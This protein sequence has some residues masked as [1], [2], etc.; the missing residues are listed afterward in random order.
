MSRIAGILYGGL[1]SYPYRTTGLK[2]GFGSLETYNGLSRPSF[3]LPTFLRG[4]S[5]RR[6]ATVTG[7]A[8]GS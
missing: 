3:F 5:A 8:A 1:L 7:P 2:W 6:P 4:A